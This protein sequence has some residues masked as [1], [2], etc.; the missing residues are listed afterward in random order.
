MTADNSPLL[1]KKAPAIKLAI[2]MPFQN[3]LKLPATRP[4]RIVSDEPPSRE[5]VTISCTCFECEL[6]KI[7]VNSGIKTAANV[8][9]LMMMASCHHNPVSGELAIRRLP[10]RS[11]LIKNE[12]EIH[13]I[14][15]IQISR[16]NGC[17]KS[18]SFRPRYLFSE[19]AWLMK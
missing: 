14:E 11:Q 18:N 19:M 8:P 5:A 4:D 12:V 17:S 3:A 15:A 7:F 10:I 1:T 6:V 2:N 13:R 16:V 9:Q